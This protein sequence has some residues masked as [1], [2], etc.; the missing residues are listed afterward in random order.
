MKFVRIDPP[1]QWCFY[2]AVNEAIARCGGRSFFEVGVGAGVL[3]RPLC[4]KGYV[5][6]GVDFSAEAAA[7]AREVMAP[8]VRAG[9]YRLIEDDLF[10]LTPGETRYA[11]GLSMMVM[12]H[13]ADDVGFVRRMAAF[14]EPGGHVILGVPG[15]RDRWSVEDETVGHLRRYERDDLARVLTDAG[16][17][18]VTVWSV[19]VPLANLLFRVG[20]LLVRASGETKK[21]ALPLEEQ[22][23][24]SGI[25]EIPF[26]TVFPSW[27]TLLLNRRTLYPLFVL[28][29]LFYGTNLGLT[30]VAFGR[31]PA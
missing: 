2:E 16:L 17:V 24:S 26:K 9:R 11:L 29:R 23:K 22:T 27:F 3:S 25:R 8:H 4:D 19:A 20:N 31:K 15:R 14:V 18:D 5:G 1:G 6:L 7:M 21:T 12:E 10:N 30:L 28:Q 13:V